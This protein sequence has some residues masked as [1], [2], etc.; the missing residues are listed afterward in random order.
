M[1]GEKIGQCACGKGGAWYADNNGTRSAQWYCEGCEDTRAN[2]Y[3]CAL[4]IAEGVM[5]DDGACGCDGTGIIGGNDYMV[6][7]WKKD[8]EEVAR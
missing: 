2:R 1:T 5:C 7:E 4:I 8:N 6:A 3:G